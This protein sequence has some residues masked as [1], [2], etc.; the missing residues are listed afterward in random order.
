MVPRARKIIW[1]PIARTTRNL[2][3]D[4]WNTRN[5]SKVYSKKLN[6][7]FTEAIERIALYP[8]ASVSTNKENIRAILVKD[9]YM[10]FEITVLNIT[11]LDIWDT[12][13]NPQNFPIQ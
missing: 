6:I 13:Q 5:K 11:V 10:V 1:T 12:R 2:I 8:E 4:Y 9:Y 7:Y 3:F